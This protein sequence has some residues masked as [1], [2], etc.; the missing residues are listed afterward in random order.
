[1][2][3]FRLSS[4]AENDLESIWIYTAQRWG[5]AQ[6]QRYTDFLADVFERLAL[7]PQTATSC[8]HIR[9]GY[10]RA[11]AQQHMV[12]FRETG[13]GIAIIRVLHHRMDPRARL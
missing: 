3:E 10:R 9:P 6:A 2:A 8:D 12:Y 11:R 13:S 5:I 4:A 1:M 7:S